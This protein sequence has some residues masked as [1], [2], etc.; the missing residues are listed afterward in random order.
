MGIAAGLLAIRNTMGAIDSIWQGYQ[1]AEN[2][3]AQASTLDRQSEID[4]QNKQIVAEQG[5]AEQGMRARRAR[6]VIGSQ[7]A[8]L[9]ESGVVSSEGSALDTLEQSAV[10]AE[11]E[12]L[13]TI[14][15]TEL[16]KRGLQ[17]QADM[18]RFNAKRARSGA[19][20]AIIGGFIGGASA[21]TG[22]ASNFYRP[23]LRPADGAS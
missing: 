4:R 6:G 14:Y 9:A 15:N 17:N 23:S 19:S 8:A 10:E 3:N 12:Q 13:T 22:A 20:K 7:R 1:E 18:S 21:A 5:T 2:L 16:Q 11:L